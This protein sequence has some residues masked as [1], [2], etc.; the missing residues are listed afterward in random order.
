MTTAEW[1]ERAKRS[2]RPPAQQTEWFIEIGDEEFAAI[3]DSAPA[4]YKCALTRDTWAAHR[5]ADRAGVPKRGPCSCGSE[6]E[7]RRAYREPGGVFACHTCNPCY[8]ASEP[9]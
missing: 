7:M 1:P 3:A 4:A 5:V 8:M 6:D 2:P 9:E